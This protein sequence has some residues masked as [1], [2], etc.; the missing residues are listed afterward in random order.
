ML[1]LTYPD[2][3]AEFQYPLRVEVGCNN[4]RDQTRQDKT[5]RFS[6][7]YGSKWV[8]TSWLGLYP[9]LKTVFQYPLRVEVGCNRV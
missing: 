3:P 1:T 5:R 4:L 7:L 9:S 8:A 2:E 6:T